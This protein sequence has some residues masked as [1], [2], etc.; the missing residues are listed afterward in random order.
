[1]AIGV[2]CYPGV[3]SASQ[4]NLEADPLSSMSMVDEENNASSSAI[5]ELLATKTIKRKAG[6]VPRIARD[7]PQSH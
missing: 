5:R 7:A 1:M 2:A 6:G 3:A 4:V